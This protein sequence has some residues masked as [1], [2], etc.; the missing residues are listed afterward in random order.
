MRRYLPILL[1][2]VLLLAPAFQN[3]ALAVESDGTEDARFRVEVRNHSGDQ[4]ILTL[5]ALDSR[6][7]YRLAVPAGRDQSFTVRAGRYAQTTFAC[8][9]SATGTLEVFQQLRLTFLPCGGPAPNAGAP[10]LEKVHL[11]D[12]PRGLKWRYQYGPLLRDLTGTGSGGGTGA[13]Q[14]TASADVTIYNRPD[15]AAQVFSTQPAGF[16]IQPSARS[17]GGWLGFEPGI[18]QA[19]NIGPFRLRWLPPGSGTLSGGCFSLPVVWTPRAG[20]CY[21]MPM[22]DTNVYESPDLSSPVLFVLH[23]GEFAQVLG[24]TTGGDWVRVDLGP[25]NTGS[26]VADWVEASSTN[27]NGPC[28]GRPVIS[29]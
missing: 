20:L 14:Y 1:V 21:D 9:G 6:D 15:T 29:P 27:V 12:S 25:G 4:A 16:T 11:T 22:F 28:S 24:S 18:A 17:T 2:L 23:L 3:G 19:A 5:A 8:G 13:C 7:V 26:R 10:T